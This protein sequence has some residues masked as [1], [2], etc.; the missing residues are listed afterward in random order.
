MSRR[1]LTISEEACS[2]QPAFRFGLAGISALMVL[3]LLV[4]L[5]VGS[6]HT[7]LTARA[8]VVDRVLARPIAGQQRQD[9]PDST[10]THRA[11]FASR[12]P[13]FA[14][15]AGNARTSSNAAGDRSPLPL[16]LREALLNLP[17]PL[18]A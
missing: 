15:I 17:P 14:M 13:R 16:H 12:A 11:A 10:S 4:G 5:S 7:L 8:I 3:G 18:C 9:E 6:T 1:D 2:S